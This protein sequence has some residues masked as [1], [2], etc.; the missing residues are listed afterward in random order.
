M[1]GITNL[2]NH[3]DIS[4][5]QLTEEDR[6]EI[7]CPLSIHDMD[8]NPVLLDV[9]QQLKPLVGYPLSKRSPRP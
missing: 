4:Q 3:I 8:R 7:Q 6:E 2:Q 1:S 9:K 5:Y